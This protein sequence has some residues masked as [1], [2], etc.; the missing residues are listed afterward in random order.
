MAPPDYRAFDDS[1]LL[2]LWAERDTLTEEARPLLEAEIEK[3]ALSRRLPAGPAA[4][5]EPMLLLD[6]E[7]PRPRRRKRGGPRLAT[8]V[9]VDGVTIDLT[10]AA[11]SEVASLLK[12]QLFSATGRTSYVLS[13]D[14]AGMVMHELAAGLFMVLVFDLGSSELTVSRAEANGWGHDDAALF[15]GALTNLT[16]APVRVQVVEPGIGLV[17]GNGSFV[18]P[19]ALAVDSIAEAAGLRSDQ[20]YVVGVPN[21]HAMIFAPQPV[22][23]ASMDRLAEL[24]ARLFDYEDAVSGALYYLEKPKNGP[25]PRWLVA[26]AP[27]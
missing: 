8:S 20:G 3:R 10:R 21:C 17:V 1:R 27:F 9:T 16:T 19:L 12:V 13:A 5:E 23:P 18:S 6:D 11:F 4:P 2:E 25:L 22:S 14:P 24:N 7:S 15:A 26:R